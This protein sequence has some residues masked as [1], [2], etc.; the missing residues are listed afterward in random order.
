MPPLCS[1]D[2]FIPPCVQILV[3]PLNELHS[4]QE[5][6]SVLEGTLIHL[7]K[8]CILS[9]FVLF[10]LERQLEFVELWLTGRVFIRHA[11]LTFFFRVNEAIHP[12]EFD[13]EDIF[14]LGILVQF[15]IFHLESIENGWKW[16]SGRG[17]MR[18]G[19]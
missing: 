11:K 10:V 13:E 19:R 1:L 15:D 4:G 7:V 18:G 17:F 14:A 2:D 9:L 3:H 6:R 8:Q 5:F 16:C 12:W